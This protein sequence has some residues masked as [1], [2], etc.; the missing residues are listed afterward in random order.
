MTNRQY[1]LLISAHLFII[2]LSNL[3]VQHPM[4]IM[5]YHT[6]WGAFSY[7]L[8]FVLSDLT[9]RLA[10]PRAA[11][12]IVYCAMLPALLL[13]LVI[14][15]W[16]E[17]GQLFVLN[18]LVL[19]IAAASCCAYTVGQLIDIAF[20]QKLRQKQQWWIAPAV[21]NIFGN[22]LDTY[23][24]F[25]VAFYQSSNPFLNQHWPEIAC[26]DLCFKLLISFL[27]VIPLYG[28]ILKKLLSRRQIVAI[29]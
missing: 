9:T 29:N 19:R 4:V 21:S 2:C 16:A 24:F 14:S 15:N 8:I 12:I 6:T 1:L 27:S 23:I 17:H 5:G 26:V 22:I 13:S 20:F 18:L 11:R 3:L 28:L 10:G 25:F 7:P